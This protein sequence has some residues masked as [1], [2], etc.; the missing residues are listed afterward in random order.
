MAVTK[1]LPHRWE[2]GDYEGALQALAARFEERHHDRWL[3]DML[4]SP[5]SEGLIRGQAD[6]AAAALDNLADESDLALPKSVAAADGF[7]AAGSHAGELRAEFEQIYAIHRSIQSADECVTK[8][9][10]L[11]RAAEVR[12]YPWLVGQAILE[13]GNCRSLLGDSGQAHRDMARALVLVRRTGYR[14]LALRAAGILANVQTDAG[15]L[16]AAWNVA[17]EGL[18]EYWTGSSPG[19]R[20]QQIYFNLM[21][22][23]ESLHLLQTAY[24]FE[25]AAAMAITETPRRR[26]EA[27]TRA[28]LAELAVEVGEPAEA[29]R[30][31][32]RASMLFDQLRKPSDQSYRVLAELSRAQAELAEGAPDAAVKRLQAIGPAAQ[33][34]GAALYRV[35]FQ[36]LLGDSYS[37]TGKLTEAEA[38]Y[39]R[40]IDLSEH[41]LDTFQGFRERAQLML[42]AG[43][44]YR[45]A[46]ELLW[47]RGDR[48]GALRLWEWFRAG[49]VPNRQRRPDLEQRRKQ[50][51]DESF[52][53]Y[54]MLPGGPVAWLFDDRG[55]EG[56]RLSISTK[57]LETTS[58]R[59]LRE[60]AEPASDVQA[61]Q[62]DARQLYDWLVAPLAGFLDPSRTLV[63]EPDGA[64]GQIPIQ[65]LMDSEGRYLGERFA[66]ATAG[67][68]ADYQLRAAV[69]LVNAAVKA[70]VVASPSL[71]DEASKTFPP[72]EGTS[73]EGESVASRF[74]APVFLTGWRATLDAVEQ[75]RPATELFHFAG[76]GFSNSGNG[77]LLL[78]PGQSD[79]EEAGI[80][81]GP[82]MAQQD[83]KRCRL[84]VLAACSTGTGEEHGPVNPESLVRGLLWAGVARVV[85][86]RW[87]VESDSSAQFMDRFYT[88]LLSGQ[89]AAA[90]LQLAARALREDKATRH[91]YFWAGFQDFGAR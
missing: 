83:W 56:L 23:A 4:A 40:A 75:F 1:W 15:N 71:G 67:G 60:C 88:H 49:E 54:T 64:V 34:V 41:R 6:L 76:H 31:F 21:R 30:E 69:P 24:V 37:L 70:L 63:I 86:S 13:Q 84:A 79:A 33:G 14:D 91:P 3:H 90:A 87:N 52:L 74:Q 5:R 72:L 32:E 53:T 39:E 48:T 68:L 16:L 73:R 8:A 61:L 46:I 29:T 25:R 27:F 78:S 55:V 35:R 36:Q 89:N 47:K 12:H 43:K 59:F 57:E 17:R 22:S 51:R 7:R 77:G 66:I 26:M 81:D 18:S 42:V 19:N 65:A 80:L 82:R 85:A 58:A 50:L 11:E 28:Y 9:L 44:A 20:A 45:G 10:A 62:R 38:A 2:P